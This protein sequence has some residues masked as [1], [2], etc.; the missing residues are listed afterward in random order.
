MN[1]FNAKG[2]NV[3]T[4]KG[5]KR[6]R[7]YKHK[8]NSK[9]SRDESVNRYRKKEK[10]KADDRRKY[11]NIEYK[12]EENYKKL[13]LDNEKKGKN[14]DFDIRKKRKVEEFNED[15]GNERRDKKRIK[16]S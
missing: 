15:R 16:R 13:H 14:G 5:S 8:F 1:T 7:K 4:L 6:T 3:H 11:N 9:I 12:K 2:S 10:Y